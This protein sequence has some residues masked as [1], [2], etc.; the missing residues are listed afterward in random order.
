MK[1]K[2]WIGPAAIA[3]VIAISLVARL[4][5]GDSAKAIEVERV[6]LR[7]VN[8]SVLASG[9][10]AYERQAQLSPEV[11]G[12][13][14]EVLVE[15]GEKVT[16][17]QILLTIED[18]Q[19]RAEVA[20]REAA[21]RLQRLR[22]DQQRLSAVNKRREFTRIAELSAKGFA[23]S[24]RFDV[25]KLDLELADVELRTGLE[26]L[27]QS[28][29]VLRQAREQLAKT[30]VR[31][32]MAGTVV[33]VNIKAGETAVPS[34]T[35]IAG[36]SFMTIA[37]SASIMADVGVD[38][39]D[40]ASVRL[41]QAVSVSSAGLQSRAIKGIVESISV[42]P[43][44]ADPS[45]GNLTSARAYS[46]KVRLNDAG[47]PLLRPGMSCRAEIYTS[48]STR[49]I[50]VPLQ[51]VLSNNKEG[52]GEGRAVNNDREESHVFVVRGGRAVKRSVRTGVSDDSY[53]EITAGLKR[54]EVIAVGPY[55]SVRF[56]VDGDA[57][58]TSASR[59]DD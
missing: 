39:A 9:S 49:S 25:A 17:G 5:G 29:A 16:R 57:V 10:L 6:D 35:G 24:S 41:G 46:V 54:G 38:E 3:A 1:S 56:L 4:G 42:S 28:E 22:I 43:R 45:S 11:L 47:A 21:V 23:A 55:K 52:D 33:A 7:S 18:E 30:V 37:D 32:P 15:E 44:R 50:A 48:T 36:S 26:S 20:Q 59:A 51:A 53:Q 40:V 8:A 13:V 19:L 31:S 58:K 34:A 2:R 27:R 12:K 14:T